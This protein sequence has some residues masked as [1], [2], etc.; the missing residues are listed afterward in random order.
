MDKMWSICGRFSHFTQIEQK[1]W[2]PWQI[3]C[4]WLADALENLLWNGLTKWINMWCRTSL[5]GPL[6]SCLIST[7]SHKNNAA[8]DD[9]SFS[10]TD[11]LKIFSSETSWPNG[12]LFYLEHLWKA[13]HYN[14][15]SSFC[16]YWKQN[17]S[18]G[19]L[20]LIGW[21]IKVF[22][23]ETTLPNGLI[24]VGASMDGSL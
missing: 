22:P 5:E 13:L 9:S 21:Y 23:S 10:S 8:M 17:M 24:F 20:F 19:F 11:T 4:Y 16:P 15:V 2:Q 14:N 1:T 12:L 18:G 3:F 7:R 6:W